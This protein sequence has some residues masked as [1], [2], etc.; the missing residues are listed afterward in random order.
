MTTITKAIIP[1]AGWGTRRL[2]I[3]KSIDKCMMPVGNRPIVD[4]VVRD[5]I[6]AGITEIFFVV[7]KGSTQL[8][9]YYSDNPALTQFLEYNGK[10]DLMELA[11]PPQH[12]TFH[13]VEQ[14]ANQKYGTAVPVSLVVPLLKKGDTVALMMGD[15]FVY[16]RDGSSELVKLMA[17][18][19]DGGSSMLSATVPEDQ[20]DRY[21]VID[22]NEDNG[23]FQAIIE[24]PTVG[25]APSN[26][27][28]ISKFILNY[29]MLSRVYNHCLIELSGEYF[30]TDPIS[31]AVL[32]KQIMTVVPIE[33]EYLD[34]GNVH[35]WL[36]A[37]EVIVNGQ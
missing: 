26:Q 4:Y 19:P 8:Q 13:Y 36:H 18:T 15:D 31:Q 24:K 33:G 32:D 21:G 35:G 12:V 9:N 2:P 10:Q 25:Q 23:T 30:I 37:N 22:F 20:V 14:D 1:V 3:T 5:C 7:N 27:I 11:R 34:C 6:K 17:A 28:N 16:N 29:D